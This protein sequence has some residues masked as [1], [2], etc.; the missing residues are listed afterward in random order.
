MTGY[1]VTHLADPP[2]NKT[3]TPKVCGHIHTLPHTS[4]PF[5]SEADYDT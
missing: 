5:D 1:E 3:C 2:E 4:R